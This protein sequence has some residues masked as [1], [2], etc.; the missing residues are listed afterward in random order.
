MPLVV[1]ASGL[2]LQHN[3]NVIFS[4]WGPATKRSY[5]YI[6]LCLFR[7]HS[8]YKSFQNIQIIYKLVFK[9]IRYNTQAIVMVTRCHPTNPICQTEVKNETNKYHE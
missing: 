1:D 3:I 7:K 6:I 9:K 4:Q 8:P 2:V 5:C